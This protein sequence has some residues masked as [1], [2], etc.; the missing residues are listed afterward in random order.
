MIA[1]ITNLQQEAYQYLIQG[2]YSKA[3]KLYEK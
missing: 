2:N 1:N 3:T